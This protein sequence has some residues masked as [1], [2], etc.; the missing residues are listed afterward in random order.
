[1]IR[2]GFSS[3]V[4]PEYFLSRKL[5]VMSDLTA[6]ELAGRLGV[7]RRRA[8]DLL[9]SG[10]IAGRQLAN[11][12]WLADSD[13]VARYEVLGDR[14]SGRTLDRD[15]AWGLL[16]EL[17]GLDADWLS[18]RTRARVRQR[19]RE[20]TSEGL[21]KAVAK[22]TVAHRYTA[23]NAERAAAELIATGRAAADTLGGDLISD[24]RRVSGY[25]RTGTPDEYAAAHF[26][27]ADISGQ[28]VVY[29]NTLPVDFNGD[30]MP[31]AVVAADLAMST[32]TRERSAG[33]RAIEELR[34]AWLD[35]R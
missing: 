15:T 18:S 7:T 10:E 2:S 21:V 26:M 29:K 23:A 25:V 22:R 8:V 30:V 28:D 6:T 20:S 19:I 13:A 5:F 17:S 1:M 31:S 3:Q 33:L 14:G 34:Q 24:Q 12:T 32:D 9:G 35:A 27:V 4:V 16:W 11:G